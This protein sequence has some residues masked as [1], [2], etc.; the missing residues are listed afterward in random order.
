MN[1][2]CEPNMTTATPARDVTWHSTAKSDWLHKVAVRGM[3]AQALHHAK[4]TFIYLF[5]L[6]YLQQEAPGLQYLGPLPLVSTCFLNE[7]V[8]QKKTLQKVPYEYD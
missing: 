1:R 7:A 2:Q 8:Y 5:G 3:T 6:G 4:Y